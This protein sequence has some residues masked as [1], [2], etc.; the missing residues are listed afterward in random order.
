M[1]IGRVSERLRISCGSCGVLSTT[2]G[3]PKVTQKLS[4][5]W[6][7]GKGIFAVFAVH[8]KGAAKRS[9]LRTG[10]FTVFTGV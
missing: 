6:A 10:V 2:G 8:K 5:L 1:G 7:R 4:I 9:D 3:Y